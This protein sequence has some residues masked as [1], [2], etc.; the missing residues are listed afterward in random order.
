MKTTKCITTR[1]NPGRSNAAWA[2]GI[3][4]L[5]QG[6]CGWIGDS[7]LIEFTGPPE[8]YR[9]SVWTLRSAVQIEK[10]DHGLRCT[11]EAQ[12]GA[13]GD[14]YGGIMVPVT[15][16]KGWRLDLAFTDPTGI[17]VAYVDAYDAQDKRVARWKTDWGK[18][19]RREAAS[20]FFVPNRSAAEFKPVESNG[21]GSVEKLHVFLRVKPGERAGFSL[22]S[23]KPIR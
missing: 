20:Y 7:E 13:S 4:L 10:K 21:T 9:S 22:Q 15:P 2:I 17:L 16:A 12:D 18:E 19:L 23:A 1:S 14:P 6:G 3:L 8:N 11:V 5:L